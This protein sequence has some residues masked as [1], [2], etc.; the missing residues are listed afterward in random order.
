MSEE[1]V[2]IQE[3]KKQRD[4]I[5]ITIIVL[6]LGTLGFFIYEWNNKSVAAD[7]CAKEN[8]SLSE[9]LHELESE[10]GSSGIELMSTDLKENLQNM[11][12]EYDSIQTNNGE[13]KDSIAAQREKVVQLLA[14][15]E[16]TKKRDARTIYK[17]KK[18]TET[19][20]KV[21]RNY[22][23]KVDS[24]N[25]L[26]VE[27]RN[28]I[29]DQKIRIDDQGNQIQDLSDQKSNLEERVKIGAKLQATP[30]V[31]TALRVRNSGSY[32]ETQRASR[33]NMI[34]AC[35]TLLENRLA[36]AGDRT[37]YMVVISPDGQVLTEGDPEYFTAN[38]QEN[39]AS[40]KRVI[41]Y[42]PDKNLDLCI[43]YDV[44]QTLQSGEYIIQL[45]SQGIQ[46]G[47]TKFALK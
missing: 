16:N 44:G 12:A 17:L 46:I 22:V 47:Q 21:M 30:P 11:L 20:R 33:T 14:D 23:H 24:L 8:T 37:I 43:F 25:R 7:A 27:Y 38:G 39:P 6:L 40:V 26:N 18:E 9:Y 42:E 15:F 36:E 19:L 28:T 4:P 45:Y 10:L 32:K 2:Q 34:R 3:K 35:A 31:A 29:A 5:Y 13:L 1:V 41:S